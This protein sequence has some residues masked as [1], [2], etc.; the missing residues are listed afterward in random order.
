MNAL[1]IAVAVIGFIAAIFWTWY[2]PLIC[3]LALSL[4]FR[5]WEA[6]AL[7]VFMDLLW[8]APGAGFH[9]LPLFTIFAVLVVWAFE[10]LRKE[11]LS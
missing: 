5:A 1:R 11:L 9:G 6:I 2:I 7:G 8:L 10:P 4:R 3:I